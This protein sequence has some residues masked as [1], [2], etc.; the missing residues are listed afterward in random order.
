MPYA[1][2]PIF[3][4]LRIARQRKALSQ[5]DLSHR[6][7]VPQSYIS[8]IE[9]GQ[10]DLQLSSLL[11]LSRALDL[12]LVLVP[13]KLLPSVQAIIRGNSAP[14]LSQE[15]PAFSQVQR[16]L[17]QLQSQAERLRSTPGSGEPI[18]QLQANLVEF[19]GLEFNNKSLIE[20]RKILKTIK[21]I[22]P[23]AK[24]GEEL[25][26]AALNLRKIRNRLAHQ[27]YESAGATRHAY[28]LD[29]EDDNG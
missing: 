13:R 9:Q 20:L 24:S 3:E 10:I 27:S 19:T 28:E 15:D 21:N 29:P 22:S 8:R 12:E 18:A 1:G 2:D 23:S 16:T 6:A 5:R 14:S 11:E 7:H 25:R 17:K 26:K 4:G